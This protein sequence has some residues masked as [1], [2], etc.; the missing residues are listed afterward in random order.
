MELLAYIGIR[1]GV[2]AYLSILRYGESTPSNLHVHG[3]S[4]LR[5]YLS[6]LYFHDMPNSWSFKDFNLVIS[7]L[8]KIYWGKVKCHEMKAVLSLVR[9]YGLYFQHSIFGL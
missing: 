8:T 5:N 3:L 4:Y 6:W 2:R 9:R 1:S 7:L